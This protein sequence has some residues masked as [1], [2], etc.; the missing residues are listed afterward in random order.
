MRR[1][2]DAEIQVS[3]SA[4]SRAL[5]VG[6]TVFAG[7]L[8]PWIPVTVG[9][10]KR[11]LFSCS[12]INTAKF[13]NIICRMRDPVAQWPPMV[14]RWSVF[15]RG[16]PTFLSLGWV[17][18]GLL[19]CAHVQVGAY[20]A[21]SLESRCQ[22]GDGESCRL[23]G[24]E[25]QNGR[26]GASSPTRAVKYF[27]LACEKRN[28]RGCHALGVVYAR[29]LLGGP[30]APR[31]ASAFTQACELGCIQSCTNLGLLLVNGEGVSRS[32]ARA[33]ELFAHACAE[34]DSAACENIEV[35]RVATGATDDLR[36]ARDIFE[37][38]CRE[39]AL[40][41]CSNLAS[42]LLSG[43]PENADVEQARDVLVRACNAK[44]A[45][46][47]Y[48]L[49]ELLR[50]RQ[51]DTDGTRIKNLYEE[52]CSGRIAMGCRRAAQRL[53]TSDGKRAALFNQQAC[54]LGIAA[55]C[56]DLAP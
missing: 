25:F 30:D 48:N 34:G 37:R 6:Q 4:R 17:I 2:V 23:R 49:A 33:I 7:T 35:L 29:G 28:A 51:E 26:G 9:V 55:A 43:H 3:T 44:S 8:E 10:R 47:C 52:A 14:V 53:E 42:L 40:E 32:L 18:V 19:G 41:A 27:E 50:T 13:M 46:A 1:A 39:G 22:S 36:R 38:G 16:R 45:P 24:M 31:A 5:E 20:A 11:E 12:A 54:K 56:A 15:S 21:P